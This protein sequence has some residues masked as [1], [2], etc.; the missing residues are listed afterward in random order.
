MLPVVFDIDK[1]TMKL[2]FIGNHVIAFFGQI[3]S[4]DIRSSVI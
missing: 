4:K 3:A 2:V 1:A